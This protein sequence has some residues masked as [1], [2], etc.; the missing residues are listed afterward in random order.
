[1]KYI[2]KKGYTDIVCY[3]VFNI[4][5]KNNTA[6]AIEVVR[7]FKPQFEPGGFSAIC[8]NNNEQV[9]SPIK[10]KEG[11][12]PFKII[13]KKGI[14]GV[15]RPKEIVSIHETSLHD[16]DLFLREN[17]EAILEDGWV[18]IYERT[19]KG[20]IKTYFDAFGVLT[21]NPN[22]YYDYNF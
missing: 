7:D 11:E 9:Y 6:M 17:P 8:L 5:E 16:K 19:P 15:I 1:M 14:W 10:D 13:C 3:R 20:K 2:N 22:P 18:R 12:K 4:D 21:N